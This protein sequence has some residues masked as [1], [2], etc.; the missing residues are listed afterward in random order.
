MKVV[1]FRDGTYGIRRA[2]WFVPGY[3]Y[4][5]FFGKYWNRPSLLG[6]DYRRSWEVAES[7]RIQLEDIGEPV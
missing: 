1:Q 3:E 6:D 5:N 7:Q 2:E 4:W